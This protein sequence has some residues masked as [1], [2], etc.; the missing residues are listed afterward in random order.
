MHDEVGLYSQFVVVGVFVSSF[1]VIFCAFLCW[2]CPSPC[3]L[4]IPSPA[5]YCQLTTHTCSS[6]HNHRSPATHTCQPST[7]KLSISTPA[8]LTIFAGLLSP[9]HALIPSHMALILCSLLTALHFILPS[10]LGL[11]LFPGLQCFLFGSLGPSFPEL[12][13][14]PIPVRSLAILPQPSEP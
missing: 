1:L 14:H 6:F 11:P 2:P 13:R 12:P 9:D 8:P 3:L 5:C 4:C 7:I 10:L